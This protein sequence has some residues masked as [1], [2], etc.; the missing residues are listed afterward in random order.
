ME[1]EP[2]PQVDVISPLITVCLAG[3]EGFEKWK[4]LQSQLHNNDRHPSITFDNYNK[5]KDAFRAQL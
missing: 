3:Q 4:E 1:V 5:T 2:E